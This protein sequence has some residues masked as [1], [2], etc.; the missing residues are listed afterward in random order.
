MLMRMGNKP[1]VEQVVPWEP[2]SCEPKLTMVQSAFFR[3]FK[4]YG[5]AMLPDNAAIRL[6]LPSGA[7]CMLGNPK[8]LP[9][10]LATVRVTDGAFFSK[11]VM[12]S[13]IGLGEAYMDGAFLTDDLYHMIEVLLTPSMTFHDLP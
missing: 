13:D 10:D 1:K 8:A 4:N 6:V 2:I 3:L 5:A 9:A 7:E 11:V 12:R